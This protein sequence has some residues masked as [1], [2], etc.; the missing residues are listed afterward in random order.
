MSLR[1]LSP[2]P[3][4]HP[5]H[6]VETMHA[7]GLAVVGVLLT[8][9]SLHATVSRATEHLDKSLGAREISLQLLFEEN[10]GQTDSRVRFLARASDALLFF[11][12]SE[13]VWSVDPPCHGGPS[14]PS[15]LPSRPSPCEERAPWVV[16]MSFVDAEDDGHLVAERPVAST[17]HYLVGASTRTWRTG[18]TNAGRLRRSHVWPGVDAVFRGRRDRFEFDFVVEPGGDPASIRL[19]F[20]GGELL[21]DDR[22]NLIVHQATRSLAQQAPVLYQEVNGRR[23]EVRGNWTILAPGLVGFQVGP[24]DNALPLVIDPVVLFS[25]YLGGSADDE[26]RDVAIDR[27]GY[28][29]L[30]GYTRSLDFPIRAGLEPSY[31]GGSYDAFVTK[32]TPDGGSVVYSTYI[33]GSGADVGTGIAVEGTDVALALTT[34]SQDLPASSAIQPTYGGGAF[35]AAVAKIVADGGTL[36][37]LT[38]LGGGGYDY[39]SSVAVDEHDG[40]IVVA[41]G[42]TSADYPLAA[43][44]QNANAGNFDVVLSRLDP[45]SDRLVFSTYFGGSDLD[46]AFALALDP[47]GRVV[48]GGGTQSSDF[49]TLHPLQPSFGGVLDGFLAVFDGYGLSSSSYLGGAGLD[50]LADLAIAGNTFLTGWTNSPDFPVTSA[51]QP[52]LAGGYDAFVT[53]VTGTG[54]TSQLLFS[55]YVGTSGEDLGLALDSREGSLFVAGR[56]SAA[57]FPTTSP[58]QATYGGGPFDVFLLQM[59][60][61]RHGPSVRFSTFIGGSGHDQ[62]SHGIA[63]SCLDSVVVA[64]WSGSTDLPTTPGS[65]QPALLGAGDGFVVRVATSSAETSLNRTISRVKHLSSCG[66][67]HNGDRGHLLARLHR[68]AHSLQKHHVDQ[69]RQSLEQLLDELVTFAPSLRSLSQ[70]VRDELSCALSEILQQI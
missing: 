48:V 35:D 6:S 4:N 37:F 32:L 38:Y 13:L 66:V 2:C 49:P 56:T 43:P 30:T 11:T 18:I 8:A 3:Q 57:D 60:Q 50:M 70:E 27:S 54:P 45:T 67:I 51:P 17:S 58:I 63:V 19:A 29:Y 16:R 25:T 46:Q 42:S 62:V 41:G 59:T 20:D 21:I 55:T 22:G 36:D 24:Y 44:L 12:D 39:A 52:Q 1:S 65:W 64:G 26:I 68:A 34:N 28:I 69:A 14:L 53:G 10:R 61:R 5:R 7:L 31:E 40:T 33:G 47:T 23:R 15:P 9:S